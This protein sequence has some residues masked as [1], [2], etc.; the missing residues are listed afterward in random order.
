MALTEKSKKKIEEEEKYR[1]QVKSKYSPVLESKTSKNRIAAALLA[2]FL[3]DFGIHKFYLGKPIQGIIYIIFF[4]TFVPG[5]IGF[6]EGIIYLL[7]SDKSFEN[8]YA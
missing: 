8:K 2:I 3:G 1:A 5:F 4:W 6:L 7:M